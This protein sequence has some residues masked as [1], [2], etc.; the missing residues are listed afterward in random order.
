LCIAPENDAQGRAVAS[1][2]DFGPYGART[3]VRRD[4]KL[5][6]KYLLIAKYLNSDQ[7][8]L[9]DGFKNG[10]RVGDLLH[11]M[12]ELTSLLS[13]APSLSGA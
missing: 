1:Y 8:E 11:S 10:F 6:K 2:V 13:R 12:I 5:M 9:V 4:V 3:L 7:S